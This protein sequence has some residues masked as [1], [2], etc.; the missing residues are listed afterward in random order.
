[1]Y[2]SAVVLLVNDVDRAVAFYT[3]KMGWEKTMDVAMGEGGRWVTVAPKGEK[4]AF[5]LTTTRPDRPE[6]KAGGH[7]GVIFEVDDV[8]RTH[9]ELERRGVV[10]TEAP[11]MEPW[12]GW[13]EFRDSEGN[14]H[15]LHS[16]AAA[17]TRPKQGRGHAEA[18]HRPAAH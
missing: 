10:F 12:G 13:A 17:A 18:E 11:R 1:M 4:A 16:P 2:M 8:H 3:Q 6:A 9:K 15:G 5:T 14:V 7:S